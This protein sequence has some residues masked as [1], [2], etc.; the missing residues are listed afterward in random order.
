MVRDIERRDRIVRHV[1]T[2]YCSH[3]RVTLG[4]EFQERP[5][6]RV[7]EALFDSGDT[8]ELMDCEFL[9]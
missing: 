8:V 6:H 7:L 9:E 2:L 4:H 1:F 3:R 5:D